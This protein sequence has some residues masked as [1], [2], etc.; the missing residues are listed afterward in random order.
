MKKDKN[1]T[2]SISQPHD[3]LVKRLLSNPDTA[4]DILRL[5]RNSRGLSDYDTMPKF[6]F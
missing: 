2:S 1:G 3:R 6:T 5:F 4:R